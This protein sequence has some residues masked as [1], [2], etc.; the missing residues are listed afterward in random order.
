M[1][2]QQLE[3]HKHAHPRGLKPPATIQLTS[4]STNIM[5]SNAPEQAKP[6]T[7]DK[8]PNWPTLIYVLGCPGAGKGT[9]CTLLSRSYKN[10]HHLSLGHHLRR[11]L[12]Q[13]NP[14]TNTAETF[15]GL[16]YADFS[17]RLHRHELLP[18]ENIVHIMH[19]AVEGIVNDFPRGTDTK[20]QIILI[21]GFPRSLASAE[22]A[23]LYF[24]IGRVGKVLLFD[25]PRELA[26]E[27]FLQRKRSADDDVDVFK[28]RYEEFEES[29]NDILNFYDGCVVDIATEKETQETWEALKR[30]LGRVFAGL[31]LEE[32]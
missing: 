26:V 18:A 27:R 24:G 2:L 16:E 28:R 5:S 8:Y 21:D 1:P 11:L 7:F 4:K 12:S 14:I 10:I 25:C 20:K 31:V 3:I 30:D 9:L 17:A 32:R 22:K 15:G 13:N 23:D 29:I 19:A 6:T